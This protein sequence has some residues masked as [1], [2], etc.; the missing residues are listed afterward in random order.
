MATTSFWLIEELQLAADAFA[1]AASDPLSAILIAVGGLITAGASLAFG[2][3][4]IGSALDT[5]GDAV[6]RSP[7]PQTG[8]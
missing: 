7:P 6:S 5:I 1:T 4:V 3:L 8:E 2:A